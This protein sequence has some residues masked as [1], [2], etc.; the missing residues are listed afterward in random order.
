MLKGEELTAAAVDS[1]SVLGTVLRTCLMQTGPLAGV[2]F[3]L[4][5]GSV[6]RWRHPRK[7]N[8]GGNAATPA[9]RAR[10]EGIQ[11]GE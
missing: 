1:V 7:G 5:A 11:G 4:M 9:G 6:M 2:G 10:E 8:F 3:S